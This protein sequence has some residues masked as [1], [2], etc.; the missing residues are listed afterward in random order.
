MRNKSIL[1]AA[2]GVYACIGGYSG[3]KRCGG[4]HLN[5]SC[6]NPHHPEHRKTP[7]TLFS[8]YTPT[9]RRNTAQ[10]TAAYGNIT[11]ADTNQFTNLRSPPLDNARNIWYNMRVDSTG[12]Q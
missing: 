8:I 1:D 6:R 3:V 2:K 5:D 10:R 4:S 11:S 7:Q 12:K 9:T